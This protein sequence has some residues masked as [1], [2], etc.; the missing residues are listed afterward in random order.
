MASKVLIVDDERDLV[1]AFVRLLGRSG[2]DCMRAFDG[3]EAICLIDREHPDL[4]VTDLNLPRASGIEV[5]RH[6]HEIS[7][8]TPVIAMTGQPDSDVFQAAE[9]AGARVCLHKPVVLAELTTA[10]RGALH[11]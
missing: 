9:R 8:D 3:Q 6:V 7:P 11:G 1:D 2:L 5:I 10:I 4:V